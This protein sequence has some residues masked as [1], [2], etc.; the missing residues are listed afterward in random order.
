VALWVSHDVRPQ[1]LSE[2]SEGQS[3]SDITPPT[4]GLDQDY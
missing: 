3:P 4:Q 2:Q 1:V